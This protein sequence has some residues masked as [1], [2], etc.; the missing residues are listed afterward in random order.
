MAFQ[1][2]MENG[3]ITWAPWYP[4]IGRSSGQCRR[5][6]PIVRLRSYQCVPPNNEAALMRAVAQQPVAVTIEALTDPCFQHYHNGV[7]D[8]RCF[9]SGV[10]MDGAC[11]TV[12]DHMIALVGYGAKPDGTK[13]WIGKNSWGQNWGENGFVYLHKRSPT[14]GLCALAESAYYP[15]IL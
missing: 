4:Y 13:Y 11:G 5:F 14:T 1:W 3:G 10:Y 2:V 7:Y 12:P 15:I 8:G 6:N 9:W